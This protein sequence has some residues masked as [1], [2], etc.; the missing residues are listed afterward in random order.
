MEVLS[1][2]MNKNTDNPIYQYELVAAIMD[3]V[4]PK[5]NDDIYFKYLVSNKIMKYLPSSN[6]PTDFI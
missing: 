5:T 1:T 2:C 3:E 6:M 4:K